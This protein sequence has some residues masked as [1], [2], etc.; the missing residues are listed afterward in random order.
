MKIDGSFKGR[1]GSSG[2]G[3]MIRNDKG[4][5]FFFGPEGFDD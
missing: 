5:I 3:G 4:A 1:V 2:L